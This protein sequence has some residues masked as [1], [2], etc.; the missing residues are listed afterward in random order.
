ME[1]VT[2]SQK[3][4]EVL[5]R[6]DTKRPL[7]VGRALLEAPKKRRQSPL[8][9]YKAKRDFSITS[10]PR[11]KRSKKRPKA[12]GNRFVVQ[13]HAARRLHY[14]LRLELDGVL[15]SWAVTRGPSLAPGDKRLSIHT[16]DHPLDYLTFEGV[17]PA[18]EYGGGIMIVWDEGR[19]Q[20]EGDPHEAY[21]N[22]RLTFTLE[23]KRLKGRW[24]LVR[25]RAKLRDA[26][27]Q[28][29]LL[30]SDDEH[31]RADG[32]DIVEAET[33]SI[34]ATERR[35]PLPV[36]HRSRVRRGSRAR[37]KAF[38]PRSSS[39]VSQSSLP[40]HRQVRTGFMK[41]SSTAI[42]CKRASTAARFAC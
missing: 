40:A 24:H 29:L 18:G 21:A 23:G 1:K 27:E 38:C 5:K 36:P 8:E 2:S 42:A 22:G 19:W 32:P 30:K 10:E 34:I 26:K 6:S 41:S 13:K 4:Q 17:I 28:W 37:G 20:P 16:E 31:A 7:A 25:T 14:D 15:K 11:A 3:P 12:D 35:S 39:P 33:T 9:N